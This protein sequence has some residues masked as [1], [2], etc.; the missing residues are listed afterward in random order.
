MPRGARTV[1]AR[2]PSPPPPPALPSALAAALTAA[3][4]TYL[5]NLDGHPSSGLYD[6]VIHEIEAPLLRLVL[7]YTEGNQTRAARLLGLSRET[8]RKKLANHDLG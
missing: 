2:R 8:L 3:V 7:A 4:S 6:L 5:E 1:S